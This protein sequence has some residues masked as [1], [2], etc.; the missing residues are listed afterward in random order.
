MSDNRSKGGDPDPAQALKKAH[1]RIFKGT[2]ESKDRPN[3]VIF[4][5][6][7]MRLQDAVLREANR[8]KSHGTKIIGVGKLPK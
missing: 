8:L 6:K 7:G 3:Y 2:G 4:V 1:Y 5:T